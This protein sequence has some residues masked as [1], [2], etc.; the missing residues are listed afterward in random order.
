MSRRISKCL[1]S[2]NVW[3]VVPKHRRV[4]WV[5]WVLDCV[6]ENP[7]AEQDVLHDVCC[8]GPLARD[9]ER[10]FGDD[11]LADECTKTR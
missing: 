11:G 10:C 8:D 6:S 3:R 4:P 2:T 7:F 1:G 9:A 5:P